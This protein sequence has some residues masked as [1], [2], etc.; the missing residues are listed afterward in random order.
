VAD[1][2]G[3]GRAD[4]VVTQHRGPTALGHNLIA[5]PGLRVR[6]AGPP[7]NP[8]GLGAAL[9]VGRDGRFGP[10]RELHAG[11]GGWAQDSAVTVLARPDGA[12]QL[13]VRWPG[14]KSAVYDLPASAREVKVTPAGLEVLAPR[15]GG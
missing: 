9:R 6:L 5:R 12:N 4:L 15:P 10:A 13:Q 8:T 3:D 11:S 7:G 2:D 1:F 14:G